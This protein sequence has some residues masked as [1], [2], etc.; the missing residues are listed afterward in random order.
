MDRYRDR[1]RTLKFDAVFFDSGG[2][3]YGYARGT[4]PTSAEVADGRFSRLAA[5]FSAY[6]HHLDPDLI[7]T[8]LIP[9]EESCIKAFGHGCNFFRMMKVFCEELT[10][11]IKPEIVACLTDAYAG[12]RYASW[13]YPGISDTVKALSESGLYIGLIANTYWPGFCMDRALD[14]VGLLRYF[15][16][17]IYS[18]DVGIAK[19]DPLIFSLAEDIAGLQ[20]KSILYVGD[21]LEPDVQGASEVGWKTAFHMRRGFSSDGKA[22]LDYNDAGELLKFCLKN[23]EH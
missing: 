15:K 18:G 12:P 20:G 16:T 11:G 6:G 7:K 2:T 1:T 5:A 13:L 14:G 9:C 19:P 10:P 8:H 17:R 21:T 4:D 3:L 23:D 22:D